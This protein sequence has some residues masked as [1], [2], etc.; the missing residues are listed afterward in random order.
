MMR[1]SDFSSRLEILSA[2]RLRALLFLITAAGFIVPNLSLYEEV[3]N[4]HYSLHHSLMHCH[5]NIPFNIL[6]WQAAGPSAVSTS[7]AACFRIKDQQR[8]QTLSLPPSC[9]NMK[10]LRGDSQSCSSMHQY[11]ADPSCR[12]QA[13]SEGTFF[14]HFCLIIKTSHS[15]FMTQNVSSP[16]FM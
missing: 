3:W 7:T 1:F 5:A 8:A 6:C 10:T 14:I 11:S 4:K 9:I 15:S 2:V 13:A 12:L 16:L